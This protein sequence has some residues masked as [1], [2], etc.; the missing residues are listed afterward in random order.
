MILPKFTIRRLLGITAVFAVISLV[1]AFA[2]RGQ[3]WAIAV[4]VVVAAL[5]AGLFVYFGF[6]LIVWVGSLVVRPFE[7]RGPVS[8][9]A[10]H[11][12]PPQIVPPE[13]S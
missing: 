11:Q 13:D 5:L 3:A 1:I 9:F 4:S 8:P 6:Y 2:V 10:Q 7:R 12:Q